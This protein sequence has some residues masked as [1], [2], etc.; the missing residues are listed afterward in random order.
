M[1]NVE[2]ML[3]TSSHQSVKDSPESRSSRGL[4]DR[5]LLTG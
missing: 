2:T 3:S 5:E 4:R 1:S